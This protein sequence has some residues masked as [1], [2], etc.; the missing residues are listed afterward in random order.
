MQSYGGP[1]GVPHQFWSSCVCD[2]KVEGLSSKAHLGEQGRRHRAAENTGLG[3]QGMTE[4]G[5]K[6][7]PNSVSE[8]GKCLASEVEFKVET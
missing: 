4:R 6:L 1:P 3:V 7:T 5:R 8:I 2:Q